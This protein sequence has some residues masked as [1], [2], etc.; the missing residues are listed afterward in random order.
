M[1]IR[2]IG[3]CFC[4]M[5]SLSRSCHNCY[6]IVLLTLTFSLHLGV[7]MCYVS[8]STHAL[9]GVHSSVDGRE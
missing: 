4:P 9:A 1:P 2:H 8:T 6:V 5:H 3:D 7:S